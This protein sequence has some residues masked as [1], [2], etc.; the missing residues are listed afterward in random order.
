MLLLTLLQIPVCAQ[1]RSRFSFPPAAPWFG[2]FSP[3]PTPCSLTQVA[4]EGP[5]HSHS[6]PC[7]THRLEQG[8]ELALSKS[9][10][11]CC[12]RPAEPAPHSPATTT[13]RAARSCRPAAGN[14]PC[15][16]RRD[17]SPA[18]PPASRL[19]L[20]IQHH[21]H[22]GGSLRLRGEWARGCSEASAR[23]ATPHLMAARGA[24]G[25]GRSLGGR[26]HSRVPVGLGA[27]PPP[28]PGQDPERAAERLQPLPRAAPARCRHAHE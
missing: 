22:G 1:V 23:T 15:E 13:E 3:A 2:P 28:V 9:R 18:P 24:G 5:S 14:E 7:P 16:Q 26:E 11:S 21:D 19:P 17:W 10:S 27:Q 8:L 20:H 6:R 25:T 12:Q 4:V